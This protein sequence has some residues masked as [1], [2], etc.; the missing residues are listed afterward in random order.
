MSNIIVANNHWANIGDAFYQLSII[1]DLNKVFQGTANVVSGEENT[2]HLDLF[3]KHYEKNIFNY[4]YYGNASWYVLSGPILKKDFGKRYLTLLKCLKQKNIK[5]V[6]ISVGGLIYNSDE[7]SHCREIL[8]EYPP[9][10]L[11]TR[12]TETFKNYKDLAENA[13][14]GICSAFYS[15]FHFQGYK[16]PNLKDYIVYSFDKYLEP[17]MQLKPTADGSSFDVDVFRTPESRFSRV[18][19]FLD[20]FREYP[21]KIAGKKIIRLN[22]NTLRKPFLIYRRPNT[23]VS[24]NPYSYLN[25]IKNSLI[26]FGTRVHACVSALSYQRPTMIFI[27]SKRSNQLFSRVGLANI[28]EKPVILKKEVL[29]EEHENLLFFLKNCYF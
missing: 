4:S 6:M 20:I 11:S 7:I 13:H 18:D 3:S 26:V 21:E 17:Y 25:I 1:N 14:D 24:I 19:Y 8:K 5:L 2:C 15:S 28:S 22:H 27:K 23:F 12:D 10:I 29:E 9:Y 16:T